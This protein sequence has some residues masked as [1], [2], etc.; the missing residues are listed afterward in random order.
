MLTTSIFDKN[1]ICLLC[2]EKRKQG[3][4]PYFSIFT[5]APAYRP[6]HEA[7]H[8]SKGDL[9]DLV[10]KQTDEETIIMKAK[11]CRMKAKLC[12]MCA[13]EGVICTIHPYPK[14]SLDPYERDPGD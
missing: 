1:G 4:T 6:T 5:C 14:D 10:E 2:T 7:W 9:M 8:R 13:T 12:S 3:I 11:L